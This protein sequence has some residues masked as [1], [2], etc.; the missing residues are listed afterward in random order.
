MHSQTYQ[1]YRNDHRGRVQHEA[2]FSEQELLARLQTL[3][4]IL[5]FY[6]TFVKTLFFSKRANLLYVKASSVKV[7][8]GLRDEEAVLR[9]KTKATEDLARLLA[10]IE[11]SLR[12]FENIVPVEIVKYT[13]Y[14][15]YQIPSDLLS[16]YHAAEELLELPDLQKQAEAL[17]D[18]YGYVQTGRN[19][20]APR[21]AQQIETHSFGEVFFPRLQALYTLLKFYAAFVD[22]LSV[23]KRAGEFYVKT[24]TVKVWSNLL[25]REAELRPKTEDEE[26]MLA[27]L[28]EVEKTLRLFEH[29]VPVKVAKYATYDSYQIPGDSLSAYRA[30]V[31]MPELSDLKKQAEAF[32]AMQG[33]GSV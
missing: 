15:S 25:E 32:F 26:R 11:K 22:S 9:S 6:A 8:S 33:G 12:M 23:A 16:V 1:N 20:F 13:G 10:E 31:E 4:V 29:V 14:D 18:R 2:S 27:F 19:S 5:E 28:I 3:Y 24:S 30:A 21:Y 7:K 17:F